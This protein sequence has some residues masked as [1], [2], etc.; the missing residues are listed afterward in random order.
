MILL[1]QYA[2]LIKHIFLKNKRIFGKRF[3]FC[4]KNIVVVE[5]FMNLGDEFMTQ[6]DFYNN[7]KIV[8]ESKEYKEML[9]FYS[10]KDELGERRRT[11][12]VKTIY[13]LVASKDF[14]GVF[15]YLDRY[16]NQLFP[17]KHMRQEKGLSEVDVEDIIAKN[18][19]VD[20]YLYHVTPSCNVNGI[21]EDGLLTLNDKYG[22]DMYHKSNEVNDIYS[23]VKERNKKEDIMKMR[24]LIRIPGITGYEKDRFNNVFLTSSLDYALKTYGENGELSKFFIRDI[25]WAFGV[26]VDF[27]GLSKTEIKNL[28]LDSIIKNKIDIYIT[29]LNILLAFIDCIY[30]ECK[31]IETN[32]KAIVMVPV[33]D[34]VSNSSV[35]KEIFNEEGYLS[36]PLEVVL[37]YNE[38]EIQNVG[39]IEPDKLIV[40]DTNKDG[41][42]S[43][44]KK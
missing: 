3:F 9:D 43:L 21:L 12:I 29:E 39:S 18:V 13:Y 25:L 8:L 14:S 11:F 20:G 34:I 37:D 6:R 36:W 42:F 10:T 24:Q 1:V 17:Y 4:Q 23:R 27:V 31:K 16:Y 15:K 7:L 32:E 28:L 30:E 26:N 19:L 35:F 40:V 22:C 33:K 44:K 5:Y 41:S 38:G 2:E